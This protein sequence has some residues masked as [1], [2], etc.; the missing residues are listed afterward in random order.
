MVWVAGTI[1]KSYINLPS[2]ALQ[3]VHKKNEICSIRRLFFVSRFHLNLL[4]TLKTIFFLLQ[5]CASRLCWEHQETWFVVSCSI[6]MQWSTHFL[7]A[8]GA[9]EHTRICVSASVVFFFADLPATSK[10][11]YLFT[12]PHPHSQEEKT[13]SV[14]YTQ[15]STKMCAEKCSWAVKSY[16]AETFE[17]HYRALMVSCCFPYFPRWALILTI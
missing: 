3:C 11:P 5:T 8:R 1:E 13:I 7:R 6:A 10:V 2:I 12:A 16:I 15:A 9:N 14:R 17:A 4:G